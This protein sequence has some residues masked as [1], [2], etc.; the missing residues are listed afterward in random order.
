MIEEELFRKTEGR[1]Y[2]YYW[3]LREMDKLKHKIVMLWKHKESIEK[4]IKTSNWSIPLQS[5]SMDY[6]KEKVTCSS[7]GTGGYAEKAA[8]KEIENLER[9]LLQTKIK[10]IKINS[11]IREYQNQSTEIE[12]HLEQLSEEYKQFIE[13]KY[14]NKTYSYTEIAEKLNFSEATARRKRKEVVA[15]M[16][17]WID[18]SV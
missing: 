4:D 10:I 18:F 9:E 14:G 13:L 8:I 3:Q 1:L 5:G 11:E 2:R 16:A 12:Y 15:D 17:K 6:T 7:V